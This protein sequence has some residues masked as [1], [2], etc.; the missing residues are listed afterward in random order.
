MSR[1]V[2]S[3]NDPGIAVPVY[4]HQPQPRRQAGLGE[5]FQA[6]RS[7]HS[8]VSGTPSNT[9]TTQSLQPGPRTAQS[10][11]SMVTAPVSLVSSI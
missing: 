9:L 1:G 5:H 4:R 7:S 2:S 10:S 8:K 11:Q 6:A 3:G